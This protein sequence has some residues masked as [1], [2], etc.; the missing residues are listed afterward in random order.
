MLAVYPLSR[1]PIADSETASDRKLAAKREPPFAAMIVEQ[2]EDSRLTESFRRR[3]EL[4]VEHSSGALGNA[5]DHHSIFLMPIWKAIG[6]SRI[7]FTARNLPKTITV[8]IV[9][10]TA[11]AALIF[12]QYKLEMTCDGKLEPQLR[13]KIFSPLDAE[14][15]EIFVDH[16]SVVEGP[17]GDKAGTLLARL[18]SN[19]IEQIGEQI[20][21]EGVEIEKQITALK[22]QLA[23][24]AK[25]LTAADITNV[26][27]QLDVALA[28]QQTNRQKQQ[29]YAL[30][31]QQLEITSPMDGVVVTWKLREKLNRLPVNR[32]Q[33]LLE[34]VDHADGPW[35]LELAMP[36]KSMGHVAR[37][38][39]AKQTAASNGSNEPVTLAVEFVLA[40]SPEKKFHGV[41]E[42]IHDR[43]EV[44][45]DTGAATAGS[46]NGVNTVLIKVRLTDP[47]KLPQSIRPGSQCTAKVECG[48]APLGYVLLH[49]AIAFVQKNVLFRFF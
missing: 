11:L 47:E 41:I 40:N 2:I 30:Q 45:T 35:Q 18:Y 33:F 20:Y 23:N 22:R 8:A 1:T 25:T 24:E 12:V 44:R 48:K 19:E 9:L 28:R 4:V 38:L 27:G 49:D 15:R 17:G 36:E 42:E 31:R 34:I 10:L 46:T 6:K 13:K 43:A 37:Q 5:I 21:G 32:G 16:D 7:L 26:S 3:V 29:L 39:I 14:V